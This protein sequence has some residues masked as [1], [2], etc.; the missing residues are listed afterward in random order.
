M[1][2]TDRSTARK[3]ITKPEIAFQRDGVGGVGECRRAL[4]GS[5]DEIGIVAV[6]DH[7]IIGMDDP[8]V[9]N[10]V[11][12]RQQGPDEDF[13]GLCPFGKPC[14]AVNAHVGQSLGVEA[15]FCAGRHDNRV[16]NALRLHQAQNLSAEVITPVG[17]AQATTRH[18]ASAQVN[19]LHAG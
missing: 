15:A 11:G 12:N 9:H 17:P 4:V 13:I 7:H 18:R 8:V 19:A 2:I 16:F 6:M 10:V 3:R 14:I 1:V 5:H